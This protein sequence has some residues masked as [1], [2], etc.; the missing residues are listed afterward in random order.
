ML[1]TIPLACFLVLLSA[2]SSRALI[3]LQGTGVGFDRSGNITQ[4]SIETKAGKSGDFEITMCE[5]SSDGNNAFFNPTPP[6]WTTLDTGTCSG[7]SCILG[8]FTRFDE[9]PEET[10]NFC[11][12]TDVTN[13]FGAGSFRYSGVDTDEP[14]IDLACG[15]GSGNTA[16]APSVNTEPNSAVIRVYAF[17][18][19]TPTLIN[20]EN[21]SLEGMFFSFP[22]LNG[23]FLVIDGQSFAFHEGGATGT[24]DF[25][26]RDPGDWRA[27]TI[28]LRMAP[29]NIPTLSEWGLG[30]FAALFGAAAVWALRR[31]AV[32]A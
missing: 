6:G 11:S 27:C 5:T 2:A 30:V 4:G 12:W 28:A 32:R 1:K 18:G 24:G 17:H 14:V 29:S 3:F 8:I 22:S 7:G 15:T 9:S 10:E 21:Q 23:E 25:I 16:T 31:R 26:F 19:F 20:Q 13:L